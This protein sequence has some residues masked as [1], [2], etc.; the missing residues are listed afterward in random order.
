MKS[1]LSLLPALALLPTWPVRGAGSQVPEP[2]KLG[3]LLP[4]ST[5]V[6][7]DAAG[8]RP[9][10][11]AG[12]GHPLI[13]ALLR[14][15]V[16]ELVAERSRTTPEI[17]LAALNVWAGRPVLPALAALTRD[18][19]LA[20]ISLSDGRPGVGVV[21]RGDAGA[22]REVVELVLTR[23]AAERDPPARELLEPR[24]G[25]GGTDVWSLGPAGFA[26]RDG[27]FL[28]S[29]DGE[30]LARMLEL[31]DLPE[32]GGL[33]GR[34]DFRAAWEAPRREGSLGWAWV[35]VAG[36]R[37]A[38]RPLAE[39]RAAAH[40][41]A[42]HLLL[43]S[44]IAQLTS[45]EQGV[46]E[47]SN[48]KASLTLLVSGLEV[49]S[50]GRELLAEVGARAPA[51]PAAVPG[52][53]ARGVLYRDF[54]SLF[55]HRLD[56]FPGNLQPGFAEAASNLALFFEGVDVSDEV[57]P[58]LDPWIGVVARRVEFD[59]GAV[60]SLPLPG[61]ALIVRMRDPE[62]LGPRL[63]S[64]FQSLLAIG[65]VEAAQRM[66]PALTLGLELH[67]GRTVTYG[68]YRKPAPG[69]GVDLRYNLVP[70]CTVVG[71]AFVIGTHLSV[72]EQV[73]S[74]VAAGALESGPPAGEWLCVAG[75]SIAELLEANR[76]A[77]VVRAVLEEGKS[78]EQARE[79]LRAVARVAD[80]LERLTLLAGRPTA[81]DLTL[82]L[83]LALDSEGERR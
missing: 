24:R 75:D 10:F 83:R 68:R 39:L 36:L 23:V 58:G 70:A 38:G 52:E 22:W 51:L 81:D 20:G 77:L 45:A 55:R 49:A 65:N 34:E 37:A 6:C 42:A 40:A 69:E 79:D 12:L 41:P 35:D 50:P 76:E 28:A 73:A 3:A 78:E 47:V 17:A 33:L 1:T 2:R 14:S 62:A 25:A 26:L 18:G 80:A 19:C 13:A 7:I 57:L 72:V 60:P 61:A 30:L 11:E 8:L 71:E 48:D 5:V 21:A 54:A 29:N 46:L 66:R 43:G 16:G 82:E 32:A 44:T 67:E 4:E 9:L 74:Q 56:V 64:A 15:P 59:P 63:V 31:A 53:M 27:L